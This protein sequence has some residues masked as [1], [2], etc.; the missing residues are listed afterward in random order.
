MEFDYTNADPFAPLECSTST[1]GGDDDFIGNLLKQGADSMESR[2]TA[3]DPQS[4]DGM[5]ALMGMFQAVLSS[6]DS[7]EDVNISMAPLGSDGKPIE[8]Q[9]V[10]SGTSGSPPSIPNRVDL[11]A[12]SGHLFVPMYQLADGMAPGQIK[13]RRVR[14][15][16][17]GMPVLDT[18]FR[19]ISVA[20]AAPA[21]PVAVAKG[22]GCCSCAVVAGA[23]YSDPRLPCAFDYPA[24]WQST[25]G[26]DGALLSAIVGPPPQSCT[27]T[28]QNGDPGMS[29]S[30]GTTYDSN[31]DTMLSIWSMGMPVVGSGRCGAGTVQFFSLPGA[32]PTGFIGGVKFYVEIGARKYG[33]YAQFSCGEPGGWLRL[34]DL[35]INSF[36][37]NP[38]STF[39]NR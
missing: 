13:E 5:E 11:P 38:G 34:R 10:G 27:T 20:G 23:T 37:D 21:Q 36:G 15:T 19:L 25:T 4:E 3:P 1:S 16:H 12:A 18:A 7:P 24:N 39:P 26:G 35:F 9:R 33:G 6:A 8:S 22:P 2:G 32:D 14:C 31:A 28:C 17:N 29:V 30:Y